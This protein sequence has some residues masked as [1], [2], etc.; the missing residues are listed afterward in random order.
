MPRKK[1]ASLLDK[2]FVVKAYLDADTYMK[3][4]FFSEQLKLPV[5]RLV[6]R[7]IKESLQL[8]PTEPVTGVQIPAG[9]MKKKE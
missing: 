4:R 2:T 8:W 1:R 6:A 9:A 7:S 5:S 3:V